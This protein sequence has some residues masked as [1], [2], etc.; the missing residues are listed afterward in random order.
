MAEV[1]KE[2]VRR[3]WD[4]EGAP[5]VA[6]RTYDDGTADDREVGL[7]EARAITAR[8]PP[9]SNPRF[10]ALRDRIKADQGI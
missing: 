10:Q 7:D 3:V 8:M 4:R 9:L 2:V 6:T 1:V 5:Y